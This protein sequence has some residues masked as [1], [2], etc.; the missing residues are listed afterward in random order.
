MGQDSTV[1]SPT[2]IVV[3][4]LLPDTVIL[5]FNLLTVLSYPARRNSLYYPAWPEPDLDASLL[6]SGRPIEA[7]VDIVALTGVTGYLAYTWGQVDLIAGWTLI[8]AG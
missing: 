8:W 7:T 2:I 5:N 3:S 4:L 1:L 6:R